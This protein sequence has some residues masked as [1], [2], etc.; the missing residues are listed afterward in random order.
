M[1][2]RRQA[3][4]GLAPGARQVGDVGET[5]TARGSGIATQFVA[6]KAQGPPKDKLKE[7]SAPGST[8]LY[9]G[10][11]PERPV[12]SGQ[13]LSGLS[14]SAAG[15]DRKHAQPFNTGSSNPPLWSP[16]RKGSAAIEIKFPSG[17]I[18]PAQAS[19]SRSALISRP[20][21][22]REEEDDYNSI[23]SH[24]SSAGTVR[25]SNLGGMTV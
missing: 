6:H 19:A 13:G 21:N 1:T 14:S 16:V 8:P 20:V 2:D 18:S 7:G 10:V 3:Q 22:T 11:Q 4:F 12:S 23:S 17:L 25:P 24:S 5:R 15:Q 9:I